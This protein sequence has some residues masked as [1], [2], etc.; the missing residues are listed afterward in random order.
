MFARPAEP[1]YNW[2]PLEPFELLGRDF[3]EA[4]IEKVDA[5]SKRPLSVTQALQ[6]FDKLN[7]TPEFFRRYLERYLVYPFDGAAA[8]LA[9]TQQ[10]V[11]ND[12]SFQKQWDALLPADREILLM[13]SEGTEDLHSQAARERL[14]KVLGLNKPAEL[15]TPQQSLRRLRASNVLVRM[16]HGEYR[17]EDEAFCEWVR[18]RG[19]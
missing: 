5:I 19:E 6:A 16:S 8:A 4:M 9:Y 18:K 17:Y 10:H 14:G 1:F 3:V 15:N 7:R 2:A 12:G 11:F 13:L